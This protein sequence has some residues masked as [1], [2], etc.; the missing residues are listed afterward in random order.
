MDNN[1][2]TFAL[3]WTPAAIS[4]S[5]DGIPTGCSFTQSAGYVIPS[6]PMFVIIQ[7][8]TGGVGGTPNDLNLPADLDVSNVTVTQPKYA[9]RQAVP[10]RPYRNH[11][12]AWTGS[13]RRGLLRMAAPT[14]NR[15]KP[16]AREPPAKSVDHRC[17]LRSRRLWF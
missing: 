11:H 10:E 8:Q 13:T 1:W 4:M 17:E 7:T 16:S 15:G 3:T 5:V 12:P 2:H 6:T 14:L 9:R